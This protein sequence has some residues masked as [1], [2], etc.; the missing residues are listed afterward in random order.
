L[1][2]P[3]FVSGH[4]FDYFEVDDAGRTAYRLTVREWTADR[5]VLAIENITAIRLAFVTLFDVGALQ[6]TFSRRDLQLMLAKFNLAPLPLA[7]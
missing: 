7:A 2:A 6:W 4:S 3:D 5:V 1:Q